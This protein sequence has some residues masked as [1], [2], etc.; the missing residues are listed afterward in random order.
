MCANL[1]SSNALYSSVAPISAYLRTK[2]SLAFWDWMVRR[3]LSWSH[4]LYLRILLFGDS[5]GPPSRFSLYSS[6][7]F[8]PASSYSALPHFSP[9]RDLWLSAWPIRTSIESV[10]SSRSDFLCKYSSCAKVS[11]VWS[12]LN[13]LSG[14]LGYMYDWFFKLLADIISKST[15][16]WSL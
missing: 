11:L 12:Y 13:V 9:V 15:T 2:S 6:L 7:R 16:L 10:S 3:M 1:A 4:G 8:I 14:V 5:W